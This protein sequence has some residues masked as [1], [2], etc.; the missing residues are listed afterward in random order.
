M[1]IGIL[2]NDLYHR[3]EYWMTNLTLKMPELSTLIIWFVRQRRKYQIILLTSWLVRCR[4]LLLLLQE[5]APCNVF[6]QLSFAYTINRA[7]L[8][9]V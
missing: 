1:G 3:C 2:I 5:I 7:T 6:Y 4:F 9:A 8:K